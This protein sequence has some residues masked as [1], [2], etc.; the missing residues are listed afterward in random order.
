MHTKKHKQSQMEK[1]EAILTDAVALLRYLSSFYDVP[2]PAT[3]F[4]PQAL[5][6]IDALGLYFPDN[7]LIILPRRKLESA[8]EV[9]AVVHEW[10]H[11][12]FH[13]GNH[14]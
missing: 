12:A 4:D 11:H 5:A 3:R 7:H 10:Q 13:A 9:Y 2:T 8:V 1:F 14:R 6:K